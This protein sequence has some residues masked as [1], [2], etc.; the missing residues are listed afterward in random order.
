MG[1][2]V[3]S[4]PLGGQ[5]VDTGVHNKCSYACTLQYTGGSTS[6]ICQNNG[7]NHRYAMTLVGYAAQRAAQD[8]WVTYLGS[9]TRQGEK[10]P[11][12]RKNTRDDQHGQLYAYLQTYRV[13]GA[14]GV[15]IDP[16]GECDSLYRRLVHVFCFLEK[17]N[18]HF[19]HHTVFHERSRAK[20]DLLQREI[21]ERLPGRTQAESVGAPVVAYDKLPGREVCALICRRHHGTVRYRYVA[22]YKR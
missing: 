7:T 12:A 11:T 14:A 8:I 15:S 21:T 13:H 18:E 2:V 9:R 3:F 20:Q 10:Q 17:A 1:L 5:I 16:N 19:P 4:T 6:L 22:R